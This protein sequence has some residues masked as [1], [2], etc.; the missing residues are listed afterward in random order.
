M[1]T[2]SWADKAGQRR[3]NVKCRGGVLFFVCALP[4]RETLM[5]RDQGGYEQFVNNDAG[6]L[7]WLAENPAVG[8]GCGGGIMIPTSAPSR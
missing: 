7:R 1:G 5:Q 2:R 8:S 6:Y 4:Q 3:H